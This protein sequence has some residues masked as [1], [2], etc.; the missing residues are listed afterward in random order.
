MFAT[1][2]TLPAIPVH[3]CHTP[4]NPSEPCLTGLTQAQVLSLRADFPVLH[5]MVRGKKPLVYLDNA[6]T[7]QKPHAVIERMNQFLRQDYGTVRRGVYDLSARATQA[8]EASRQAVAEFIGAKTSEEIVFTKGTTEAINLVA[9]SY[10]YAH[11]K[12]GDEV[13]LSE[14]EHHANIVPWQLLAQRLGLVIKVIPVFDSGELDLE[15]YRALFSERTKFVSIVHVSN[16][17]GT[18]NPVAE[19]IAYAHTMGVPVLLDGAQSAP[20]MCVD[21]QALDADF[22][23]FSGHKVYGPSAVGVLY[24]KMKHLETMVPYQGGGDM[25]DTVS[26][27]GSTFAPPPRRFEA[28]TPPMVE[29]IGLHAALTYVQSIGMEAIDTYERY[30]LDY[31]TQQ[32]SDIPGLRI[33]GQAKDKAG[34][35]SFTLEGVHPHDIGT[36]LDHEGIAIRAGHH[37]AQPVMTRFGVPATARASFAFYNTLD[38]IDVLSQALR[39]VVAFF[40]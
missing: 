12:Q 17:L 13:I 38:D 40:A 39:R 19:M 10:G 9:H 5:Q 22:Y 7:T 3:G 28:G 36:M 25:I 30:L 8:F 24:G 11:F 21:V 33:I 20:H 37:C 1:S 35:I 31:A 27:D 34:I 23:V 18:V 32:L 29:V 14:I 26:F 6:A 2:M 15:T 16:A 4:E